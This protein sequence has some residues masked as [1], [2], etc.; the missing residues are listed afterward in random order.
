MTRLMILIVGMLWLGVTQAG[1]GAKIYQQSCA[2]CHDH[3]AFDAPR[4]GDSR[5]WAPRFA[6]GSYLLNRHAI[7]GYQGAVGYMPPRGGDPSLSDQDVELAVR[8]I[9]DQSW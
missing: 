6:K 9:L 3:G 2:S 5:A 8:H 1:Q 4:L 7:E